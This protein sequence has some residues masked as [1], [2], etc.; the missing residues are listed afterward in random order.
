MFI[1]FNLTFLPMHVLGVLGMQRR[2]ATYPVETGFL[3]WNVL[4]TIGAFLMFFAIG[5]FVTNIARSLRW[6]APAGPDPWRANTLEWYAASPPP[7]YN[8]RIIPRVAS[9]RPLRD[10]RLRA[11]AEAAASAGAAPSGQ[12]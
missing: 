12:S 8:F 3:P 9:E 7:A 11:A 2:I 4:E 5:I 6:G 1:G 10:L